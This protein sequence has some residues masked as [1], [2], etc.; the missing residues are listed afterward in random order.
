MESIDSELIEML[1]RKAPEHLTIEEIERLSARLDK[2]PELQ[3]FLI[4]QLQMEQYLAAAL[5]RIDVR[6]DDIIAGRRRKVTP[7]GGRGRFGVA[8]A[9]LVLILVGVAAGGVAWYRAGRGGAADG[10]QVANGEKAREEQASGGPTAAAPQYPPPVIA[11]APDKGA[12][13]DTSSNQHSVNTTGQPATNSGSQSSA[14]ADKQV[15]LDGAV[16]QQGA[17]TAAQPRSAPRSPVDT[18]TAP[19]WESQLAAPPRPWA[20]IVLAAPPSR[21]LALQGD[22]PVQW[23]AAAGP[24]SK[25][26][27][28]WPDDAMLRL[29][30]S[31]KSSCEV[32]LWKGNE[33]ALFQ[34]AGNAG[35]SSYHATRDPGQ[36]E[37][38]LRELWE[39]DDGLYWKF[40]NV[41]IAN[42]KK[43]RG[44]I[45]FDR[46]VHT[47][48][49]P[50]DLF[51][52]DGV[53]Q[54]WRGDLRL[55]SAPLPAP[56]D[57]V[58]LKMDGQLE[59]LSIDRI[60][61]PPTQPRHE[62]V[63]A[64]DSAQPA[65]LAW[66]RQAAA[67]ATIENGPDG[68]LKLSTPEGAQPARASVALP[69]PGICDV[70]FKIQ[71]AT[72]GTGVYLGGPDGAPI[73]G[74][75]LVETAA[76][77]HNELSLTAPWEGAP[78]APIAAAAP[79]P[80]WARLL[81]ASGAVKCWQSRDGRH[82]AYI[83]AKPLPA[84]APPISTYGIYAAAGTKPAR[85]IMLKQIQVRDYS[86]LNS[87][88]PPE[89][90]TKAPAVPSP[91]AQ[92]WKQTAVQSLPGGVDRGAWHRAV[93]LRT[94]ASGAPQEVCSWLL[95]ALLKDAGNLPRSVEQ[96]RRLLAEFPDVAQMGWVS[97][98]DGRPQQP[99]MGDLV[100]AAGEFA[101]AAQS[102]GETRPF[103]ALGRQV[104]AARMGAFPELKYEFPDNLVLPELMQLAAAERYD[105]MEQ[106]AHAAQLYGRDE[107]AS[108]AQWALE[109]A[110]KRRRG[111]TSAAAGL[112]G[113]RGGE[114]QLSIDTTKAQR[115]YG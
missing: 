50:V 35:W 41:E 48:D 11:A 110:A 92:A 108:A 8:A 18:K 23:L 25:L 67:P 39:T 29:R 100:A 84:G 45:R 44:K 57:D 5:S 111:D 43:A 62:P 20:S 104:I 95:R 63:V 109:L 14:V 56:P 37:P 10:E 73:A 4:E 83:G 106:T 72:N 98:A 26:R 60:E 2:S 99:I 22:E 68:G 54:L 47:N 107:V 33:G 28:P 40:H 13:R 52:H 101:D 81:V 61:K 70:I 76:P 94:I 24:L 74:V 90:L 34:L 9:L 112:A 1:E 32:R 113:G 49:T 93:A 3:K 96:N 91:N 65:T 15:A 27:A 12:A 77:G 75:Q 6:V 115:M 38:K 86:G 55:A 16:K 30:I 21:G 85:T 71:G 64:V 80:I 31:T 53:V 103:T 105:E 89:L 97:P 59:H 7:N 36:A 79:S 102:E 78:A 114:N 51:W 42:F 66:S 46:I 17:G 87:L 82:W 19:P 88:A 58:Y 69:V